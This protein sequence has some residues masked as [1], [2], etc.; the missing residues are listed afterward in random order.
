MSLI[1][2][3]L[4]NTIYQT[5]QANTGSTLLQGITNAN[6][7]L[8]LSHQLN[9]LNPYDIAF[10]DALKNVPADTLGYDKLNSKK[11]LLSFLIRLHDPKT[12]TSDLVYL[13]KLASPNGKFLVQLKL[14]EHNLND[15][16]KYYDEA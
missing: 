3:G 12:G 13:K 14:A 1:F 6:P 4:A 11:L 9:Q 10:Q 2:Q 15:I 8:S 16:F 7:Y 5:A